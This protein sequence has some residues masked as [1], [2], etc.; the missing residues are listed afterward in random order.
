MDAKKL[1]FVCDV[2]RQIDL[3]RMSSWY[4]FVA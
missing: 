4:T 3:W 1:V 2:N